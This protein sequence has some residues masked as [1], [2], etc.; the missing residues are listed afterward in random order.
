ME[1]KGKDCYNAI[2]N[3]STVKMNKRMIEIRVGGLVGNLTLSHKMA[4]CGNDPVT[5][6]GRGVARYPP[7]GVG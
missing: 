5:P 2:S 6:D 3:T 4:T 1:T 7:G